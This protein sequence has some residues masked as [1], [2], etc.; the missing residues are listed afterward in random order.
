MKLKKTKAQQEMVGFILIVVLVMIGLVVFMVISVK[1][2]PK[3]TSSLKVENMLGAIMKET[4][5][6][7]IP[8]EPF[9]KNFEDLFKSCYKDSECDNLNKS[10]CDYLNESLTKTLS[11][12]MDSEATISAYELD[13]SVR[14]D[15][16][17]QGLLKISSGNCTGEVSGAQ[18]SVVA[19]SE[20]LIIR[21]KI[22]GEI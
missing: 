6:C 11:A 4:T 22:C 2:S 8:A 7:A 13:F 9:Y 16:G 12:L 5:E 10:A 15:E 21:M 20:S 18:R 3:E 19:G 14:E 1:N 17:Q